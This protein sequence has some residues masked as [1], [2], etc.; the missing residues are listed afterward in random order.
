[1]GGIDLDMASHESVDSFAQRFQQR[2]SHAV[3]LHSVIVNTGISCGTG[4]DARGVEE[5]V[6]VNVVGPVRLALS[7][8][9]LLARDSNATVAFSSSPSARGW[10]GTSEQLFRWDYDLRV[11]SRACVFHAHHLSHHGARAGR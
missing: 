3:P 8:L 9:P 2:F 11:S 10:V 7:L 4:L 1:M 5:T 6:A